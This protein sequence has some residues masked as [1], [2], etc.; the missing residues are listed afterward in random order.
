MVGGN[1]AK[2][3]VVEG[4]KREKMYS[5]HFLRRFFHPRLYTP[6]FQIPIAEVMASTWR[7]EAFKNGYL[8]ECKECLLSNWFSALWLHF[9]PALEGSIVRQFDGRFIVQWECAS[10]V[11]VIFESAFIAELLSSNPLLEGNHKFDAL[12]AYDYSRFR[13]IFLHGPWYVYSK[14]WKNTRKMSSRTWLFT[15]LFM[16]RLFS[17][18]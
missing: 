7:K 14:L 15:K 5:S 17:S 3:I 2:R 12:C 10:L 1:G 18:Y 13:V 4:E 8:L 11:N 6:E 9:F 16:I